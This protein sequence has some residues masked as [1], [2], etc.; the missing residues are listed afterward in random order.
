MSNWKLYSLFLFIAITS[1]I[2]LTAIWEETG[3][4]HND[5]MFYL[6]LAYNIADGQG[7]TVHEKTMTTWPPVYSLLIAVSKFLLPVSIFWA[8]KLTNI[9]VLV[10]LFILIIW[11]ARYESPLY[12]WLLTLAPVLSLFT[13]T[14]SEPLFITGC[15]L[16]ILVLYKAIRTGKNSLLFFA[17]CFP[18]FLFMIRYIGFSAGGVVITVAIVLYLKNFKKQAGYLVLGGLFSIIATA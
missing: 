17:G 11:F 3:G 12:L 14:L 2:I 8:G 10:S 16:F 15:L 18:F 4:M 6:H 7:L 9:V 13:Q 1:C 5:S